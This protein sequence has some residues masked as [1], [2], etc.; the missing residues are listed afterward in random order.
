MEHR[1]APRD[2]T[3]CS[4]E[5]SSSYIEGT[6]VREAWL[7]TAADRVKQISWLDREAWKNLDIH[8]RAS[9]LNAVGRVLGEVYGVPTPPLLIETSEDRYAFGAYG[10]GYT[11]NA[12]TDEVK[13]ADYRILM[14]SLAETDREKLF[15]DDPAAALRTYAH[16]FRHSYQ[17]IQ[18]E[19]FKKPQFRNLVDDPVAAQSWIHQYIS[20][21]EDYE[22][23]KAQPVERD[24]CDFAKALVKRVFG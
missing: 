15:G 8:E 16:E 13:G 22:A 5:R 14:N 1:K 18:T 19:R 6:Q 3:A 7:D 20:P 21:E 17:A 23:Y 4:G 12:E 10:D 24:S 2:S 9:A 11:F